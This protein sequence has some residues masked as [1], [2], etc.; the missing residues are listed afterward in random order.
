M[1]YEFLSNRRAQGIHKLAQELISS[2]PRDM[3]DK[4]N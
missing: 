3:Y 4:I 1:S 2:N